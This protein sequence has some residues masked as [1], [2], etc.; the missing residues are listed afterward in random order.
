[1]HLTCKTAMEQTDWI[2]EQENIKLSKEIEAALLKL[3]KNNIVL[4]GRK[5]GGNIS[6]NEHLTIQRTIQAAK[7]CIAIDT[8]QQKEDGVSDSTIVI[9]KAEE[10]VIDN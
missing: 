3:T 5:M 9:I 6:F 1:M 4:M 8:K 7:A 2:A 10:L